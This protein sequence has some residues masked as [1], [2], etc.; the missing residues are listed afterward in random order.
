[1][2]CI[3]VHNNNNNNKELNVTTNKRFFFDYQTM[4]KDYT[5]QT[6]LKQNLFNI[7]AY[8][9]VKGFFGYTTTKKKQHQKNNNFDKMTRISLKKQK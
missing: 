3:S 9:N 2:F 6:T 4:R 1:M 8:E 5:E 7:F